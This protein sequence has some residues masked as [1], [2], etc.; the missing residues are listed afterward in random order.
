MLLLVLQLVLLA[1]KGLGNVAKASK[2]AAV[3]GAAT[4]MAK[5]FGGTAKQMPFK[6]GTPAKIQTLPNT[7]STGGNIVPLNAAK[8]KKNT[9]A[10]EA[11]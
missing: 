1:A 2:P 7:P 4:G 9:G 10:M 6:S 11:I 5:T 8:M 3:G